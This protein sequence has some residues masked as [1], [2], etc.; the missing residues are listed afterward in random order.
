MTCENAVTPAQFALPGAWPTTYIGGVD[1]SHGSSGPRKPQLPPRPT[2]YKGIRMRSRLEAAYA[3]WLDEQ[4]WTWEYEP[5]AFANES[6]QYLPDF[7]IHG[8]VDLLENREA[9]AY[10]DVKP[11][12]LDLDLEALF[13]KM[14]VIWDSEPDAILLVQA[15]PDTEMSSGSGGF[16]VS[17]MIAVRLHT[18]TSSGDFRNTV[19][20]AWHHDLQGRPVLAYPKPPTLCPWFGEYWSVRD[21]A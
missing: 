21:P 15:R 10:L 4:R 17:P 12:F 9:T 19:M 16:L 20:A 5:R 3:A 8:V 14:E 13:V 6:G 18:V 7:K 11:S 2:T 1:V